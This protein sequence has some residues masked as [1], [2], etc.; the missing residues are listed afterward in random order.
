MGF[1][2]RILLL[3][4]NNWGAF[5]SFIVEASMK[6]FSA[7]QLPRQHEQDNYNDDVQIEHFQSSTKHFAG[8]Q[9]RGIVEDHMGGLTLREHTDRALPAPFFLSHRTPLPTN[10]EE[11]AIFIR[12]SPPNSVLAFRN[13]Q[14][15]KLDAVIDREIPDRTTLAKPDTRTPRTCHLPDPSSRFDA[16]FCICRHWGER[17]LHQFLFGFPLV[18]RLSQTG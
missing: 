16:S 5:R 6:P 10:T 1:L 15:R 7:E 12:D 8:K 3:R 2:G 13:A 4:I 14:L 11:A 17:W 9:R 18:G